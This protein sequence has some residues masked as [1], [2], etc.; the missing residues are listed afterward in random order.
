MDAGKDNP[1]SETDDQ[2]D[3]VPRMVPAC[4]MYAGRP[5]MLEKVEQVL[6]VTQNS[7]V[8]VGIG[9]AAARILEQYILNG[10]SS[11]VLDKV[12]ADLSDSQRTNP[13]DMDRAIVGFLRQ[14]KET[15]GLDHHTAVTKSFRKNWHLPESFQ[16]A[17]HGVL[18]AKDYI[19]SV[20]TTINVGGCNASR[21]GF[22]GAC[23]AARFGLASIPENWREKTKTYPEILYLAKS[24]T[25]ILQ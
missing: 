25:E 2:I 1:G 4:A 5:E 9:L 6:R 11:E 7:E 21:S 8:A 16:S 15:Q 13:K 14:V 24:L 23:S 20:R 22:V 19:G 17:L 18:T 10:D 3:C 12:I